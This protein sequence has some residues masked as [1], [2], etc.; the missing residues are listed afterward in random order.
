[1]HVTHKST[2]IF[3]YLVEINCQMRASGR[4]RQISRS[5]VVKYLNDNFH[6]KLQLIQKSLYNIIHWLCAQKEFILHINLKNPL[7]LKYHH[8][9]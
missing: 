5:L 4:F 7:V 1:M 2:S 9:N 8:S 6:Q 3:D